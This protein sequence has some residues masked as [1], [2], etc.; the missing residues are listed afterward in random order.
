MRS[1]GELVLASNLKSY[2]IP[3][4][5][6]YKFHPGRRWRFDFAFPDRKLAVEVEGGIHGYGRHNRPQGYINDMEKYNAAT[7]LGWKL[8][9]FT[10]KQVKVGLAVL[11]IRKELGLL[12]VGERI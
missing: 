5:E 12:E 9:R 8:L 4:E 3:F 11:E 1:I 7:S 10:T 6:E 2:N